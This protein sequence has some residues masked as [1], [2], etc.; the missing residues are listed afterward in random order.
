MIRDHYITYN[1]PNAFLSLSDFP[2]PLISTLVL[3]TIL[4]LLSYQTT[5]LLNDL[6]FQSSHRHSLPLYKLHIYLLS[7]E[8]SPLALLAHT[9]R[10]DTLTRLRL[11]RDIPASTT[12]A[13]D[14]AGIRATTLLLLLVALCVAPVVNVGSVILGLEYEEVVSFDEASFGGIRLGVNQNLSVVHSKP[15]VRG[16][17]EMAMR[18][19]RGEMAAA[20]FVRCEYEIEGGGSGESG[21]GVR[22]GVVGEGRGI[23]VWVWGGGGGRG[24]LVRGE[25][26]GEMDEGVVVRGVVGEVEGRKVVEW[27]VGV[28]GEKCGGVSEGMGGVEVWEGRDDKGVV[29]EGFEGRVECGDNVEDLGAVLEAVAEKVTFVEGEGVGVGMIREGGVVEWRSGGEMGFVRRRRKWVGLGGVVLAVVAVVA[30]RGVVLGVK[31]GGGGVNDVGRGILVLV[32]RWG[33]IEWWEGVGGW[34]W[35]MVRFDCKYQNGVG[36]QAWYGVERAGGDA[37]EEFEGGVVGGCDAKQSCK[38]HT[39]CNCLDVCT[40]FVNDNSE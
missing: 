12:I 19:G 2:P 13:R 4:T 23:G 7:R 36:G 1:P 3:A 32:K 31:R 9:F 5:S 33:G 29:V 35:R 28:L 27:G 8:C 38:M 20:R 40:N 30:M 14:A 26:V 16:C 6:L 24:V 37:V 11:R 22:V 10:S 39:C 25:L 18:L 15:F 34:E 17:D 21:S